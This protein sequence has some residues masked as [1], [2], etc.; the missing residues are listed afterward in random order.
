MKKIG[1]WHHNQNF[2]KSKSNFISKYIFVKYFCVAS[3]KCMAIR[4]VLIPILLVPA[5]IENFKVHVA[6]VTLVHEIHQWTANKWCRFWPPFC[7]TVSRENFQ[8]LIGDWWLL[9]IDLILN[10]LWNDPFCF[11]MYIYIILDCSMLMF[12][13]SFLVTLLRCVPAAVRLGACIGV[14][15]NSQQ[16]SSPDVL[17][18]GNQQ[19]VIRSHHTHCKVKTARLSHGSHCQ[20]APQYQLI[21][22]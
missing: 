7:A 11:V 3:R 1:V 17:L 20:T 9:C 13:F 2:D 22:V 14:T 19:V 12:Y 10:W 16:G 8:S 5:G 15:P 4:C 18:F 6:V 21:I